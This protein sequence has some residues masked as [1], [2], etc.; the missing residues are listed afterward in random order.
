MKFGNKFWLILFREYISPELFAVR[1]K[2]VFDVHTRTASERL[3]LVLLQ[4]WRLNDQTIGGF[5]CITLG[6]FYTV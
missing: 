4:L 5:I 3:K 2:K 1:M 6:D